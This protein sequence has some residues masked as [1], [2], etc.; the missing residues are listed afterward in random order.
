MRYKS[1]KIFVV[2]VVLFSFTL[3]QAGLIY[4]GSFFEPKKASAGIIPDPQGEVS[5]KKG[6][7]L[8]S[9]SDEQLSSE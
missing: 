2:V 1:L 5:L 8:I 6:W 3:S 9:P 7:N 4:L